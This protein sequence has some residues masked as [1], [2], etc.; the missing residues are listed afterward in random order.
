MKSLSWFIALLLL[1]L[2]ISAS[3]L[4][5]VNH[6]L[7]NAH[8]LKSQADKANVYTDLSAKLP[9]LLA[10]MNN[11][12]AVK[13]AKT[14]QVASNLLTSTELKKRLNTALD[15]IETYFKTGGPEP[16][17]DI[18][19]LVKQARLQGLE[20]PKN[21]DQPVTIPLSKAPN[22]VKKAFGLVQHDQLYAYGIV[23]LLL[24]LLILL[25]FMT[26]N[27]AAL[28]FVLVVTGIT[29]LILYVVSS[30]I[31]TLLLSKITLNGPAADFKPTIQ[32]LI[33]GLSHGLGNQLLLS[34][35]ILFVLGII[36]YLLPKF[37][38]HPKA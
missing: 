16:T 1:P 25:G 15:Q 35:I 27:F 21:F 23:T 13:R 30:R 4:F 7:L 5:I 12:S 33:L 22:Q 36:V 32:N 24:I 38:F 26:R 19:D 29:H 28:G 31:P 2:F 3:L 10:S 37:I 8:F 11:E 34:G 17:L 6:S 18:T 14:T 20:L 9:N